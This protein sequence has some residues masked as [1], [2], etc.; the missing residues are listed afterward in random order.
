MKAG[1]LLT[2]TKSV[3]FFR[4]GPEA[5]PLFLINIKGTHGCILTIQTHVATH[6][7]YM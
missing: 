5:I 7:M 4:K 6:D 1:C 2:H 3:L